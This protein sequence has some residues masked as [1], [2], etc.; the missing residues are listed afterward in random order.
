[1]HPSLLSRVL[2][3]LERLHEKHD[4]P[5]FLLGPVKASL[6]QQ[7]SDLVKSEVNYHRQR[8][9]LEMMHLEGAISQL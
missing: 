3:S 7:S 4:S 5:A 1:M 6:T 8:R 9:W 2:I